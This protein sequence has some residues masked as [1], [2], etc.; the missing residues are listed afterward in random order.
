MLATKPHSHRQINVYN[1]AR[2]D[3][4]QRFVL[5]ELPAAYYDAAVGTCKAC[6]LYDFASPKVCVE[7]PAIELLK[8]L[9][10]K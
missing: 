8:R 7:C 5:H 1:P 9:M 10:R 2:W 4:T 3:M 6:A